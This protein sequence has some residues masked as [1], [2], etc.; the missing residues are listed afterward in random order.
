MIGGRSSLRTS[1]ES[2]S[3]H[4]QLMHPSLGDALHERHR[5][6]ERGRARRTSASAPPVEHR[7][8]ATCR[9]PTTSSCAR[10]E[11]DDQRLPFGQGRRELKA[12][13]VRTHLSRSGPHAALP[14]A[15]ALAAPAAPWSSPPTAA[16]AA[17]AGT[18]AG[19]GEAAAGGGSTG[20]L[21]ATYPSGP[22]PF[23]CCCWTGTAAGAGLG[24]GEEAAPERCDAATCDEARGL[25][26]EEAVEGG[27][28]A[29]SSREVVDAEG[30]A[31]CAASEAVAK[32]EY[33]SVRREISGVAVS[34]RTSR[35]ARGRQRERARDAPP[36]QLG[37]AMLLPSTRLN[38]ILVLIHLRGRGVPSWSACVE[39]YWLLRRGGA[40]TAE[41]VVEPE[42]AADG[43][44]GPGDELEGV[45]VPPVWSEAAAGRGHGVSV[46]RLED[47]EGRGRTDGRV[48]ADAGEVA[49]RVRASVH[50]SVCV[51]ERK[52]GR[53]P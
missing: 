38:A 26:V 5:G 3:V 22:T 31:R 36:C 13:G 20:G 48:E 51:L 49:A 28:E 21:G 23:C 40:P 30:L 10:N 4:A 29:S 46:E 32:G 43:R 12:L 14:P 47:E 9:S 17:A 33:E 35:R 6:I 18:G 37:S 2:R 34:S 11:R 52:R 41:V 8:R 45:T 15:A 53:T 24:A 7:R 42:A 19:A 39:M 16:A 25:A 27:G 1:I 44:E 50:E